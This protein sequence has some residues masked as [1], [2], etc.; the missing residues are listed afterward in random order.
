MYWCVVAVGVGAGTGKNFI[1]EGEVWAV[2]CMAGA[3][4]ALQRETACQ[5]I[6]LCSKALF[7]L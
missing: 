7:V 5:N 2:V 1:K 4:P 6:T 3:A